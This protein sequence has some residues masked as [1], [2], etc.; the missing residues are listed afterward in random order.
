MEGTLPAFSPVPPVPAKLTPPKL[1]IVMK[2]YPRLSETFIAQELLSLQRRGVDFEIWSLRAPTDGR[3]H[4][5]H[6]AITAPVR[7]LPE[8]LYQAPRRVFG[9]WWRMRAKPGYATVRKL[10]LRDLARDP[11]PNRVRRFGQALVLADELPPATS[12]LYVHFL[13]TPASVTRYAATIRD[14]S[15]SCSAHAKDIY[16]IAPWDAGEKLRDMAWLVTCTAAN[17][18]HLRGANPAAA[19][20]VHLQ[21]H[22]I[23]GARFRAVPRRP[24]TADGSGPDPVRI[25]SIGRAVPKKGYDLL[26]QALAQ[27]PAQLNWRFEHVGG[28]DGLSALQAQAAALGLSQRITWAGAATQDTV[29]ERLRA[30]DLFVLASRIADDG[31]RDGLPNVLMEAQSQGL[32]CISTAVSAIPELIRDGETGLLVPPDNVPAL[33]AGLARLIRDPALR[34]SLGAAG[35]ARVRAAFAHDAT[36][37]T[38]ID[39][40]SPRLVKSTRKPAGGA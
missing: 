37:D 17:V 10:W 31:D 27:L 9:A 15:W 40:L 3:R 24:T 16:T 26:L 21:Y 36:I 13:H 30:A 29:L 6:E 11:T 32:A 19:D 1:A 7:Y 34:Q 20:K 23:D 25:L 12:H 18:A 39:L 22:G 2:G 14:L 4:G 28:G 38:L 35:N 5:L 8:Y 33:T